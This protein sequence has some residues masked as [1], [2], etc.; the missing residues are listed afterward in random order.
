ML[1]KLILLIRSVNID[2]LVDIHLCFQVGSGQVLVVEYHPQILRH[3]VGQ[4]VLGRIR[5]ILANFSVSIDLTSTKYRPEIYFLGP[6]TFEMGI[7]T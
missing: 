2:I 1:F 7:T 6:Y 4:E 3:Q 5:V